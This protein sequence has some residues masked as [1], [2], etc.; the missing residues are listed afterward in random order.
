[1]LSYTAKL[2]SPWNSGPGHAPSQCSRSRSLS[3]QQVT[4]PPG[5]RAQPPAAPTLAARDLWDFRAPTP[6]CAFLRLRAASILSGMFTELLDSPVPNGALQ[7]VCICLY[8]LLD[9]AAFCSARPRMAWAEP[10]RTS[11]FHF[12]RNPDFRVFTRI[13]VNRVARTRVK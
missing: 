7:N 8:M 13:R 10:W 5:L 11:F 9:S 3:V 2:G 6:F 1:M 12:C 4:L